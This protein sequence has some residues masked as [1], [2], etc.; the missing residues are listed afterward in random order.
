MH[1]DEERQL[2]FREKAATMVST[3]PFDKILRTLAPF[4]K[5]SSRLSLSQEDAAAAAYSVLLIYRRTLIATLSA[6]CLL[7]RR[8][9]VK[10]QNYNFSG[11]KHKN[12]F[13]SRHLTP[14]CTTPNLQIHGK[15]PLLYVYAMGE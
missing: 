14:H 1:H 4:I 12:R 8:E 15:K 5:R 9:A 11:K 10:S 7:G 13:S 3:P 6:D 2:F